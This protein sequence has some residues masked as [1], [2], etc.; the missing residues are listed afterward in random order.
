M[1]ER[2][3]GCVQSTLFRAGEAGYECFRIPAVVTAKS[4]VILAFAEGRKESQ[5]DYADVDLALKRS[6]DNG[7]TWSELRFIVDDGDHTMGNPCPIVDARTGVIHLLFCRDNKQAFAMKSS[8][9]GET[10]STPVEITSSAMD[11]RFYFV[12]TG[13][14]HGIQLASGRLI[15]PSA[16]V[17]SKKL[18]T[19]EQGSYIIYSD[20]GGETWAVGGILERGKTDECE[21]V[22][23]ADGRLYLFGRGRAFGRCRGYSH[24]ADEGMTWTPTTFDPQLP[25]PSCQGS[26]IRV[27]QSPPADRNRIVVANPAN[28]YGRAQLTL[29]MS[30]DEAVSWPVSKVLYEGA[31]AYSDLAVTADEHIICLYEADD[32]TRIACARL[33]VKWL[34]Q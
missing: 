19:D 15:A 31:A 14:G 6:L 18:F 21:V 25:E 16:Y 7:S 34:T 11:S 5:D 9:D 24:S 29:R 30:Y 33:G 10:W 32:Y 4:G 27:S 28:V 20:D 1:S 12:F 2:S 23:L 8:D 26:I 17:C 22:Q 13:P 3:S